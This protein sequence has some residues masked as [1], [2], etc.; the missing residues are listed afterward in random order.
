EVSILNYQDQH[1]DRANPREAVAAIVEHVRRVQPDVVVTLGP[2][3]AYGHHDH[4]AICQFTTPTIVAAADSA[5]LCDGIE[6]AQAHTVSKLYYIA[7]SESAWN[8]YQAAF[9]KLVSTVDGIE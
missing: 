7:W 1:L 2:D 4:I 6:A 8:A 3:G 5:F 9:R